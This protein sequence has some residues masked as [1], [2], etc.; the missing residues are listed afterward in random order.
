MFTEQ[1]LQKYAD[2]E[3]VKKYTTKLDLMTSKTME[4]FSTLREEVEK[5]LVSIDRGNMIGESNKNINLFHRYTSRLAEEKL[6]L[7]ALESKQTKMEGELF[8]YYRNHSDIS[9]QLKSETAIGRYV[10]SH[11]CYI[12]LNNYIKTQQV[13]VQ[14]IED[15]TK[16]LRDRGFAVKNVIEAVKIELGM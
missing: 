6:A 1:Q 10:F 11:D 2:E 7:H 15:I 13:L 9:S 12:S 8:D 16:T 5:E 4:K 14:Y 3:A